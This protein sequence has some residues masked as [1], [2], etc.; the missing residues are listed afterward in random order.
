M[1]N[2]IAF[3]FFLILGCVSAAAAALDHS[4]A[5]LFQVRTQHGAWNAGLEITLAEGWKTYWRLPG[6]SGVP[7][8]FDWSRSTNL[9]AVA[10][11]WPAPRRFSDAAGETIGYHD[12]IVLPL[13]VDP[14]NPQ[15]PVG[16]ALSLFY[17]VCKDICIPVQ[18][19]LAVEIQ[20][21]G[22][23]NAA[24]Q[25]LLEDFA[26]RI[27][28]NPGAGSLPPIHALRVTGSGPSS[29]LEVTVA[30]K[31]PA[32]ST[33]IFVEGYPKAY[34][35]KPIAAEGMNDASRF[36]LKIDGLTDVAELRGRKLT[37]TLTSGARS[38]VQTIT[39][40]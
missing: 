33:D 3:V 22:D 19:E 23:G 9:A 10:I 36:H 29:A 18:E 24:D 7:P 35:H 12:R 25:A 16:L 15:K 40:E 17:A 34:F 4:A 11:G 27:P 21:H 6:D 28:S 8:Q 1:L 31:M 39:V 30:G 26:S 13:R 37:L 38:L 14:A 20:P 5:R 2:P 32:A